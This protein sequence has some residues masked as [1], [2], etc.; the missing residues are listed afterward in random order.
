[1]KLQIHTGAFYAENVVSFFCP[2]TSITRRFF[3]DVHFSPVASS[4]L[5]SVKGPA[6]QHRVD[7]QP[8]SEPAEPRGQKNNRL[9]HIGRI[10]STAFRKAT[11][12]RLKCA[13]HARTG[14]VRAYALYGPHQS[15]GETAIPLIL[16]VKS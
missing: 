9:I 10:V 6:L 2:T 1:M 3:V 12:L 7:Q 4:Q 16:V 8:W 14:H 13:W 15:G 11:Q 5:R